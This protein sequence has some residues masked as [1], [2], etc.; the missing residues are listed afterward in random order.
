[1][2][3]ELGLGARAREE[4]RGEDRWPAVPPMPGRGVAEPDADWRAAPGQDKASS[5]GAGCSGPEQPTLCEQSTLP[6]R[7]AVRK[8]WVRLTD[9]EQAVR[10]SMIYHAV[11]VEGRSQRRVA[12]IW[13][14][15]PG[16]VS[17]I[18]KDMRRMAAFVPDGHAQIVELV[19][20]WR[21]AN[22]RELR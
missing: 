12:Q 21:E 13:R 3:E 2:R 1:M 16:R 19:E 20:V 14:L 5:R 6:E 4:R 7:P 8:R 10:D 9:S 11:L 15:T 17:Q 22:S 18:V